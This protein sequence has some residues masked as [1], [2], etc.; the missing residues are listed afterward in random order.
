M[1]ARTIEQARH[2]AVEKEKPLRI[3]TVN[4]GSTSL[5]LAVFENEKP[6]HSSEVEYDFAAL[7]SAQDIAA[8]IDKLA[9]I[10]SQEI[11]KCGVESIDAISA[12]GGLLPRPK[13]GLKGGTYIIADKRDGDVIVDDQIVA[14]V[15]DHA[16]MPHASNIAIPVAA[17]LARRLKV[18]AF[19]VDPVVVDEFDDN[20]G[21]SGYA[22]IVRRNV[23]HA[24]SVRAAAKK[25]S[26]MVARPLQD[27]N[28][29]VAH[30]GGGITVAAVKGG[31]V[32]DTN[33]AL[34]GEGPFSPRRV[35]QLPMSE[36]IDLCYSGK[37][38]REE[39]IAELTTKGGLK[40]YLN[41]HRMD[42]IEERIKSGDENASGIV[43]AMVYQI[44]KEIGSAF[45]AAGTDVEAIVLT[46]GLTRS[47][48][49]VKSLRKR[50]GK[51]APVIVFE[52]SLEMEALAA[53]AMDVLRG[54]SKGLR[55]EL[56]E[57]ADND[58]ERK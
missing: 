31:T 13:G 39:L 42:I 2:A 28:L 32:V 29:V 58:K 17:E 27:M 40:S 9:D 51:L 8:E 55:Y 12:R 5:K 57:Q 26:R 52:G 7:H 20:A 4:P 49:V 19:T 23:C 53:G 21:T 1:R 46:G 25:A 44:S 18:P 14:G 43:E 37:F 38:S 54:K 11:D 22:G 24:L 56:P 33:I 35:G 6:L 30:L 45:V 34:L 41:E 15:R 16:L 47:S 3:L 36:L 48:L 50:V 10:C